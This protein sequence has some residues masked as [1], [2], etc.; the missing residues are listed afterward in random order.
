MCPTAV[1]TNC[2]TGVASF[3]R[4]SAAPF[5]RTSRYVSVVPWGTIR[6]VTLQLI[7][8]WRNATHLEYPDPTNLVDTNWDD[9]ERWDVAS[10]LDTGT[11]LRGFMGLSPCRVCGQPNGS[12][13]Y[14]DGTLLWPEGLAH[15]V[16]DHSVR[17][18]AS[19]EEYILQESAWLEATQVSQDWWVAGAPSPI[20]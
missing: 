1:Q 9:D 2:P 18:P 19:I 13:E 20:P 7:G 4:R 12:G 6:T 17:L 11:Y 5:C 3:R 16:R 15:Y 10:Y 8:Y 14:T